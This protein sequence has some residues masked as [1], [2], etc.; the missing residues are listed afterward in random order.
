V[1]WRTPD[2][3]HTAGIERGTATSNFYE[4]RDNLYITT[5]GS[6]L[7]FP[8]LCTPTGTLTPPNP[9]AAQLGCADRAAMMP[10]RRRTRAHYIAH[11]RRHN[12]RARH[13]EQR[14]REKIRIIANDEPPPF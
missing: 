3:Y 12:R 8:T 4:T 1:S 14:R 7:L 13:A 10:K 2:T 6:A 9:D 11:Q 5:L